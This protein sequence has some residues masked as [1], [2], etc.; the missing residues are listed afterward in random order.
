MNPVI[1]QQGTGP[2]ILG[3]P[4]GGT[5]VPVDILARLNDRG[6]A[7]TDTDWHINR[8]YNGLLADATVVQATF[9]RYVID[10]NRDPA[11]G[12]LYPGQ[13]TTGLCPVTDFDG[14]PIWDKPPDAVDIDARRLQ[15]HAPYH[16]A[17]AAEVARVKALHGVAIVFDCHS[18]RSNIPFLFPGQL[19][20]F[21]IGTND[22]STCANAVADAVFG[23]C[24]ASADTVL[25]GRFKGGWT[26]RHYGVPA[27]S[28]HAIQMEIAQR[29]YLDTESAPWDYAPAK[30][31]RLRETLAECLHALDRLARS[32]QLT[33]GAPNA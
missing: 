15:F 27:Q 21:N 9:H 16:A 24:F 19:P 11:G 4:H 1:V 31:D 32:G 20:V 5:L 3:Q 22:G 13:N 33:N 18:I 23:P 29:A 28:T 14:L 2:I 12:S 30:A 6:R 25:N 7:L 10:A 8:L 26:T 17:L